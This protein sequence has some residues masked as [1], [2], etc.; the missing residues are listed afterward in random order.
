MYVIGQNINS[1]EHVRPSGDYREDCELSFGPIFIK[2]GTRLP[3]N[4]PK[5][6][7]LAVPEMGVV[8]VT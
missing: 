2:F 8:R 4:I 1:L 3:L 6:M 5:K 7:F